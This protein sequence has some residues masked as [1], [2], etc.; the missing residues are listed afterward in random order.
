MANAATEV[1]NIHEDVLWGKEKVINDVP[2]VIKEL[3]FG[4]L[5]AIR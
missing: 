5:Y 3:Q 2:K 1:R 4:V